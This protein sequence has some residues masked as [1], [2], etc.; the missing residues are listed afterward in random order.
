MTNKEKDSAKYDFVEAN[1]SEEA[2]KDFYEG[3]KHLEK[4]DFIEAGNSFADYKIGN[5][6]FDA[7]VPSYFHRQVVEGQV[8]NALRSLEEN[9]FYSAGSDL[10]LVEN[11]LKKDCP[12]MEGQTIY[13]NKVQNIKK[14]LMNKCFN[15]MDLSL[16]DKDA[17]ELEMQIDFLESYFNHE[18]KELKEKYFGKIDEYR[19]KVAEQDFNEY[20]E[21]EMEYAQYEAESEEFEREWEKNDKEIKK[22]LEDLE[23]FPREIE[24]HAFEDESP[25]IGYS[26]LK[27]EDRQINEKEGIYLINNKGNSK[28]TF[29]N[30]SLENRLN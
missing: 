25:V 9:D 26:V 21:R 10:W 27:K 12:D 16:L 28:V 23:N 30:S 14:D 18:G 19:K 3:I 29:G 2:R 20:L 7:E 11:Y 15:Q 24:A 13:L 5:F 4:G 8:E 6:D 22:G 1:S 17:F